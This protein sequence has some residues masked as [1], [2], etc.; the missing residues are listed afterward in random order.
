VPLQNLVVT[1]KLSR[2]LEEYRSSSPSSCAATQLAC[3]GKLLRPGQMVRFLYMLGLPGVHA[4]DLL[5]SP[6][7]TRIQYDRYSKLLLRAAGTL[8]E[9]FGVDERTL[10]SW[11]FYH[12]GFRQETS[13]PMRLFSLAQFV[14]SKYKS[15]QE[16]AV[17]DRPIC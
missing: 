11:I 12:T 4:W 16:I 14:M 9:P 17:D 7:P 13:R 2:N 15:G 3:E 1:Q 6:D 8:L 5:A 10:H